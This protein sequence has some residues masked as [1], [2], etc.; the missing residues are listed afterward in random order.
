MIMIL[1]R[2]VSASGF[3]EVRVRWVAPGETRNESGRGPPQMHDDEPDDWSVRMRVVNEC[4]P[5]MHT[6]IEAEV[7]G[8]SDHDTKRFVHREVAQ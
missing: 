3:W 8:G 6:E 5:V 7:T 4:K 1:L 2:H